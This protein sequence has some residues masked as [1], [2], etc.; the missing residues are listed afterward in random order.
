MDAQV[1]AGARSKGA[2]PVL[3]LGACKT[4]CDVTGAGCA[5]DK[6][7]DKD[8]DWLSARTNADA[9]LPPNISVSAAFNA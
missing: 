9:G 1:V 7:D 2:K 8:E 3:L 5:D 4:G 6:D